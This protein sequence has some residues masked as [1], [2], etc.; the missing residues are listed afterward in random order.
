MGAI[1][2]AQTAD[3]GESCGSQSPQNAFGAR[4]H[5]ASGHLTLH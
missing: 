4:L 3:R 2:L 5:S 1:E